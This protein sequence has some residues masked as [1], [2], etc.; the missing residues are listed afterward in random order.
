LTAGFTVRTL[1]I[2]VVRNEAFG[3]QLLSSEDIEGKKASEAMIPLGC[4]GME[5]G[6]VGDAKVSSKEVN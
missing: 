4:K 2:F 6:I 3:F 5:D 1:S